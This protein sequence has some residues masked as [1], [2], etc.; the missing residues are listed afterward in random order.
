MN[1]AGSVELML[2]NAE[3]KRYVVLCLAQIATILLLDTEKTYFLRHCL[4]V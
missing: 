1:H 3:A 2:P 4:L